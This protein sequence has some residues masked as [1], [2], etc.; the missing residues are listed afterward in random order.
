MYAD[1]AVLIN[2][3]SVEVKKGGRGLKQ[4][5]SII[6]MWRLSNKENGATSHALCAD[7]EKSF[8]NTRNK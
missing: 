3:A 4:Q 2:Q 1:P 7:S 5:S 8:S 6:G